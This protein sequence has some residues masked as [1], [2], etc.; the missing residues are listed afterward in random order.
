LSAGWQVEAQIAA[1]VAPLNFKTDS[2][3]G[4]TLLRVW[5]RLTPLRV[6]RFSVG[7]ALG[8]GAAVILASD[9][10]PDGGP[11]AASLRLLAGYRI[12]PRVQIQLLGGL[13]VFPK[14]EQWKQPFYETSLRLE[15]E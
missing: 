3:L 2:P 9:N 11:W 5:G 7:V 6:S 10:V 8:A 13:S 15:F 12:R 4:L 14:G 1:T